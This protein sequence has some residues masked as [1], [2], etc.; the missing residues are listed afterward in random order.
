MTV[1]WSLPSIT[2]SHFVSGVYPV[3]M[4]I[5]RVND[6]QLRFKFIYFSMTLYMLMTTRSTSTSHRLIRAVSSLQSSKSV[7]MG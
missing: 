7:L 6:E 5:Y 4:L 1:F 2:P 3:T